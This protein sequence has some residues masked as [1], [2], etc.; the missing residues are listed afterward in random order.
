MIYAG[1]DVAKADH[2]IGAADGRGEEQGK[3]MPLKN[4]AAGFERCEARLGGVAE[5]PG[6]A[7]VGME[8]TGHHRMAPYAFLVSR[9]YSVAV[10][11]PVQASAVRRFKGLD[12][13]KN[14][15][16]DAALIAE[17]LRIGQY[18]PTRLATDEVQSLRT[19]TRYPAVPQGRARRGEDP[20]H[21]PAGLVLPRVL[22]RVLRH[23]RR[24]RARGAL[25]EPAAVADRQEGGSAPCSAASPRRPGAA[26]AWTARPPSSRRSRRR[27][28]AS[29]SARTP[30]RCRSSRSSAR[31]TSSAASAGRVERR[32]RELLEPVGPLVLAIPGVS[33]T[34]GARIVAE[35]GDMGRFRSASALV[36]YA[37]LNSSVNQSG[38]FDSGGGPITKHGSPCLRRALWLAA[39]RARRGDPSAQG[40]LREGEARGASATGVAVTAVARKLCHIVFAVMRDGVPYDPARPGRGPIKASGIRFSRCGGERMRIGQMNRS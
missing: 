28:S 21:V 1:V 4:S 27:P 19:L 2:A 3:R 23:V 29:G 16:V 5:A 34:T 13:A 32:V 17:A 38:K 40:L 10:V 14:D 39:N 9:G 35:I 25:Q 15:R 18:D 36:G 31:R 24:R 37:G 7:L 33:Y 20:A 8:A 22:R 6:D 12:K 26:A 30:R 11:D